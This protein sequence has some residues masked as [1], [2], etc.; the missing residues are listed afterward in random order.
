MS[1][2]NAIW[3]RRWFPSMYKYTEHQWQYIHCMSMAWRAPMSYWVSPPPVDPEF[4][5]RFPWATC[6]DDLLASAR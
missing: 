5:K 4:K 6:V 1:G 2:Y 3:I